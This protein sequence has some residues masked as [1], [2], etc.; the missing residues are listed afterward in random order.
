M[1]PLLSIIAAG[2][3]GIAFQLYLLQD[4]LLRIAKAL[5][6]GDDGKI[7]SQVDDDAIREWVDKICDGPKERTDAEAENDSP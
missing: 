3:V 1:I 4:S 2:V 5:D 7:E 6:G